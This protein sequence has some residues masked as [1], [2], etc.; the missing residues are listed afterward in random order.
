MCRAVRIFVC[1]RRIEKTRIKYN[2]SPECENRIEEKIGKEEER[3]ENAAYER[4]WF[5]KVFFPTMKEYSQKVLL[6]SRVTE[7][8]L[9]T[10]QIRI[11][12]EKTDFLLI[13]TIE[14]SKK[15]SSRHLPII[16]KKI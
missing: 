13:N 7:M 5:G 4:T 11:M 2:N 14:K 9:I 6:Y 15:F 8:A 16:Q 1:E 3:F 12:P 10:S